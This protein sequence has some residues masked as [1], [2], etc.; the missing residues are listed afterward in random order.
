MWSSKAVNF[1]GNIATAIARGTS[2]V[3]VSALVAMM[4][5]TGSD[6]TLRYIFNRPIPGSMEVTEF[7]MAMV[8][9]LGLAY[10]ALQKGHVRVDIV[11]SRLP[12]LAQVVMN[13]IASFIFLGLFILITWRTAYRA[14]SMMDQGLVSQVLYIP[15]YPFALVVTA[16]CAV[17]CLVLLK[18]FIEDL[19]QVVKK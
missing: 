18:D 9:G 10:C 3:G 19:Y 1:V 12:R 4:F 11:L 8:I 5:L 17:L 14:E 7:M 13:S 2:V 6:V 15:V 16:G